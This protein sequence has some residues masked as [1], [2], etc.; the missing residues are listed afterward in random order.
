MK[1]MAFKPLSNAMLAHFSKI[2]PVK[3]NDQLFLRKTVNSFG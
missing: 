2:L 1:K 3:L